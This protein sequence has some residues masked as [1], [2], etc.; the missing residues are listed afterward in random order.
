MQHSGE[1]KTAK[2]CS[3]VLCLVF[4]IFFSASTDAMAGEQ[5]MKQKVQG[6]GPSSK[7][8]QVFFKAFAKKKEAAGYSFDVE[9]RSVKHAGGIRASNVF[10]FGRTGRPLSAD[11][12]SPGKKDLFLA[13]APVGFVAGL[14]AGVN[15]LSVQQV[16]SIYCRTVRS[17]S[18]V[19]GAD[20]PIYVTGR[21]SRE[22]ALTVLRLDYPFLDQARYDLTLKRDHAVIN[23]L[24]TD[25]GRHAIA[26]G[27]LLNFE[28]AHRVDISGYSPAIAMGLVYDV[29]NAE[30][31]V[32][33]AARQFA[34]S[35]EWTKM[36]TRLG[37]LAPPTSHDLQ[38]E[39]I[40][41]PENVC[42]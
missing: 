9:E 25:L 8:A 27:P 10:L 36:I 24:K 23:F 18:E 11:E 7:V 41:H 22:A 42:Q 39:I 31:P 4:S 17:W 33:H 13:R 3:S 14:D 34:A 21:E 38:N 29:R 26:Y 37:F 19:G 2:T 32:V 30:H 1:L 12:K 20:A 16:L 40:R 15:S 35:P 6:A 5:I 28:T